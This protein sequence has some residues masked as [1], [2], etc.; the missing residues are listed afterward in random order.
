MRGW[1]RFNCLDQDAPAWDERAAV[2]V[3]LCRRHLG[4]AGAGE[5]IVVADLGCGN[6]RL[7]RMLAARL[8]WPHEYHG[9]DLQ[10][11]SR[12][13]VR[14]DLQRQLPPEPVGLACALGVLEYIADV[15]DFVRRLRAF[16]PAAVLS[17]TIFDC[18]RPL[19][20]PEREQRGWRSHYTRDQ[21]E[22]L[23]VSA[24]YRIEERVSVSQ[25]RTLVWL[26]RRHD[27]LA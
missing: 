14:I 13:T 21:F 16:A 7:E 18:P 19:S 5:K 1:H 17:Y 9:Y 4:P 26:V 12:R 10:P 2:A 8:E 11:Q 27:R 25:D 15:P 23:L 3:D 22:T 20:P 6:R 24:G